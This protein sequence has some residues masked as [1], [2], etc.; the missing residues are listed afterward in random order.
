MISVIIPTTR[1][2]RVGQTVASLIAG[3]AGVEQ[4]IVIVTPYSDELDPETRAVIVVVETDTVYPPGRMRNLGVAAAQ[5][6]TICFVDDD[7]VVPDGW[8]AALTAALDDA[9]DVGAVGCRVV[10][11]PGFWSRCADFSL[12]APYQFVTR[13]RRDLGS[14][15]LAVR[16]RAFDEA[17]GF[18]EDLRASEDWEF[19]FRLHACGWATLFEPAVTVRHH[20][21]RDRYRSIMRS[22]WDFGFRSGLIV[23]TR[24]RDQMS[25]LAK[26]SILLRHP[27]F[28]WVLIL[29][30]AFI[31]SLALIPEFM[32]ANPRYILYLPFVIDARVSYHAGVWS[33]LA[34]DEKKSRDAAG[35]R[36]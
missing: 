11:P 9:D 3:N 5:G 22:A 35:E 8:S 25:A 29:P 12:F 27:G 24:H 26:L 17:G 34:A 32:R 31:V 15:A 13:G 7:C 2:G 20:H 16:R 23:Q 10:G 30:Y 33:R 1:P 36:K 21:G 14:A 18:D 6:E 19:C 4:E 28:Y